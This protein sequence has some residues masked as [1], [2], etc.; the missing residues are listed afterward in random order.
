MKLYKLSEREWA[1]A[2]ETD[3]DA[4]HPT[5]KMSVKTNLQTAEGMLQA[6]ILFDEAQARKIVR[7]TRP[8]KVDLSDKASVQKFLEPKNQSGLTGRAARFFEW[9]AG[10]NTQSAHELAEQMQQPWYVARSYIE[11]EAK[12]REA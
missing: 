5:V 12:A 6:I 3:I 1:L 2:I 10:A 7:E 8:A 11:R 9:Q 4:N